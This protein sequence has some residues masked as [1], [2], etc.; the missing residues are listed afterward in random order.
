MVSSN[1]AAL[2]DSAIARVSQLDTGTLSPFALAYTASAVATR[3][4]LGWSDPTAQSYLDR[5]WAARLTN[6]DGSL[7]GW[8]SPLSSSIYT[9]TVADHVGPVLV[10]ACRS[11]QT[12]VDAATLLALG[13]TIMA[14][15][16]TFSAGGW[17]PSYL[18]TAANSTNVANITAACCMLLEQ[19]KAAGVTVPPLSAGGNSSVSVALQFGRTIAAGYQVSSHNWAYN[20]LS[21]T[22]LNDADHLSLLAEASLTLLLPY[23]HHVGEH[24]MRTTY[25]GN[26]EISAPLGHMRF[27]GTAFGLPWADNWLSEA[28]AYQAAQVADSVRQ[29]QIARWA[30]RIAFAGA[31]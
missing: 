23:G 29:A 9:I 18:I 28:Q 24:L 26:G 17:W 8:S 2:A 5:V 4:P 22:Q 7:K 31:L 20:S 21:T 16:M 10:E 6:A 3:S 13:R 15:P 19:I 14:C 11:G 27:G 1:W 30:A 12:W 25:T